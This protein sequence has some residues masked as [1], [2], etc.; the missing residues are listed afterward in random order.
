[1][2]E[3]GGEKGINSKPLHDFN[4]IITGTTTDRYPLY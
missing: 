3:V 2:F 4:S 1:M